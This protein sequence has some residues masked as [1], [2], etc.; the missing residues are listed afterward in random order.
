MDLQRTANMLDGADDPTNFNA[1][2]YGVPDG[3]ASALGPE[4]DTYAVTSDTGAPSGASYTV[5][6]SG[7]PYAPPAASGA[8]PTVTFDP[9]TVTANPGAGEST[10]AYSGGW[11]GSGS[12]AGAGAGSGAAAGKKTAGGTSTAFYV[13]ALVLVLGVVWFFTRK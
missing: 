11:L 3:G 10:G 2:I 4:S 9:L 6:A 5:P 13:Y 12:A 1:A 7:G 8:A